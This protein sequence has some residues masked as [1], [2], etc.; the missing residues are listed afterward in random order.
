[1]VSLLHDDTMLTLEN[2]TETMT[3]T[4][5]HLERETTTPSGVSPTVFTSEITNQADTNAMLALK[6]ELVGFSVR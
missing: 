5:K 4:E 6:A 3:H 1:M 2:T